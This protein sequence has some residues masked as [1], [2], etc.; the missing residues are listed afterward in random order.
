[1]LREKKNYYLMLYLHM[2]ELEAF[3]FFFCFQGNYYYNNK[4]EKLF[5]YSCDKPL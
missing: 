1:M 5:I 4:I 3:F 2:K